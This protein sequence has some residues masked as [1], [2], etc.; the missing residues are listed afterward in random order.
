VGA[1]SKPAPFLFDAI[2]RE[3]ERR[4]GSPWFPALPSNKP[5]N[6][7]TTWATPCFSLIAAWAAAMRAMGMRMGEQDT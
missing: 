2:G 6:A 4:A 1:G 7:R 3:F 5:Y